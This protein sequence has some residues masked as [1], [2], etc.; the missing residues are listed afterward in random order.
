MTSP[1]VKIQR[2][3]KRHG[4]TKC[5]KAY[6]APVPGGEPLGRLPHYENNY[7]PLSINYKKF[8]DKKNGKV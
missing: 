1:E 7:G 2:F 4:V 6:C 8:D 3:V 5:P